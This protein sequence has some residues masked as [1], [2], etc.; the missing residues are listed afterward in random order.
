MLSC[1]AI[2]TLFMNSFQI[3]SDTNQISFAEQ[4][5][6][7]ERVL[8]AYQQKD[9]LLR[10]VFMDSIGV[11]PPTAVFFRAFKNESKFEVWAMHPKK[12]VFKLV[13]TYPICHKS[14]VIGPKREEGDRQ[15]P[16]GFYKINVF[17]P[18]SNFYLSLG[19]NYPNQSDSILTTNTDSPGSDIYIHGDCVSIGCIPLTDEYI[20]EI[21][22]IATYAHSAG[23][24]EIPVHIFPFNY[25]KP[26]Y[27]KLLATYS[28]PVLKNFWYNLKD[29]FD[30]FQN[31]KLLPEVSVDE[32]GKYLF[33]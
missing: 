3:K 23:Q 10:K 5:L 18:Q 25:A 15:V 14:G 29:G 11:Y 19:L 4:Q 28:N 12:N 9:T 27:T 20:K 7:N 2:V 1:I 13:K 22:L 21:Y 6:K 31:K 17:N 32:N 33:K 16:E 30:Y 8:E 24:Q 26:V